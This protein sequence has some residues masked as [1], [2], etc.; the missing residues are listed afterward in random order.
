P[1]YTILSYIIIVMLYLVVEHYNKHQKGL[2]NIFK[3]ALFQLNRTIQVYMQKNQSDVDGDEWRPAVVCIS[4]HSFEREK[5][6]DLMKW[7]SYQHG[8]GTYFHFI[9]G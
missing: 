7:I 9:E 5:V 3:G 1:L 2:V 4:P 6:L 8:F